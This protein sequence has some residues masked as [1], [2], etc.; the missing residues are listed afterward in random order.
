MEKFINK[1]AAKK[2]IFGTF[3]TV[4]KLFSIYF[5]GLE[6]GIEFFVLWHPYRIFAQQI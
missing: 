1:K 5:N 6:L 3:I 2:W 4:C